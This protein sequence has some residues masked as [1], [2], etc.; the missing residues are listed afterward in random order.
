MKN[1][2]ECGLTTPENRRL[3]G[4]QIKVFKILKILVMKILIEIFFQARKIIELEDMR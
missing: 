3:R 1:D 4:H 2:K